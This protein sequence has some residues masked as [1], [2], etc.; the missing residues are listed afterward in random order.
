MCE[1]YLHTKT[2]SCAL[3][4]QIFFHFMN[5]TKYAIVVKNFF[6][7]IPIDINVNSVCTTDFGA[8]FRIIRHINDCCEYGHKI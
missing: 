2:R 1:H 3:R 7:Y 5:T 6:F 8:K 4:L